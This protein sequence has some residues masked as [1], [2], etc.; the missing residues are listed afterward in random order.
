MPPFFCAPRGR[1]AHDVLRFARILATTLAL[2][3]VSGS[4]PGPS[5]ARS[6]GL[7]LIECR[8]ADPYTGVGHAGSGAGAPVAEPTPAGDG[9]APTTARG[10][11]RMRGEATSVRRLSASEASSRSTNRS[12]LGFLHDLHL[13]RAGMCAFSSVT[14]PPYGA[15]AGN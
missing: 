2:F 5:I 6:T 15:G 8:N 9:P 10:P 1:P 14:P 3:A 4:R 12:I 13:A 11:A 7:P